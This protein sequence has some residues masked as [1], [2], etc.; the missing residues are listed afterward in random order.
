L[1]HR[2]AGRALFT[3]WRGDAFIEAPL[4]AFARSARWCIA[5]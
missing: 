5:R 2:G 4:T 3:R 1:S